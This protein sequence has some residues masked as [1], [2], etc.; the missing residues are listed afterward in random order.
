M[1]KN[2]LDLLAFIGKTKI[3]NDLKNINQGVEKKRSY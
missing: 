1:I 2:D 3:E